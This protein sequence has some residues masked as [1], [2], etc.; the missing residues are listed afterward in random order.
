MKEKILNLF[1]FPAPFR[2]VYPLYW[3]GALVLLVTLDLASKKVVTDY[4]NFHISLPQAQGEEIGPQHKALY[5]G[6][7]QYDV[8]GD[9]GSLIKLRLVFNDRF[10]FG[11]GPAA[12]VWGFFLTL[13]AIV[14]LFLYRWHN[15]DMGH[16]VAWLFVFSGA[17][18][19]L[20]DK[21]FV[22]SLT[23]REWML[24]IMPQKGY[25]SGVVDFVECIWFGM[26]RFDD[27][28]P[29]RWLAWRSWPTF[30]LADS[31]IVVAILWLIVTIPWREEARD[32]AGKSSTRKG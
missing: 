20:I 23:T 6:H 29:L 30:N 11:S 2:S 18:G 13:S 14:F 1:R 24:S 32:A 10:V 22:K 9:Q 7:D 16:R 12:P 8:L 17:L 27:V 5:A 19:N 4:L 21:M 15:Y 3:L 26:D 25:V 28:W 31:L